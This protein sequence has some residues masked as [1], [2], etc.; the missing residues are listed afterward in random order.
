MKKISM[1]LVVTMLCM[2]FPF[3]GSLVYA[4]VPYSGIVI[5]SGLS[6]AMGII[7][8]PDDK[9]YISDYGGNKI[10]KMDKDGSNL[11]TLTTNV[12][13]PIGLAFDNSGNLLVA[14]Y[15]GHR[16]K[17]VD[18][19]GNTTL[20]KG[21][22][23]QLTG[24]VVDS[25]NKIFVIDYSYGKIY[26]MDADGSNSA[27]FATVLKGSSAVTSSLIGLGIDASDNLYLSDQRNARILKID[28]NG[29]QSDFASVSAPYWASVG[30]NGY[31]YASAI[32]RTIQKFDLSGNKIET[33]STGTYIPWGTQVDTG[34]SIY[35]V[36]FG[37]NVNKILGYADTV[38]RT[39]VKIT[40][41]YDLVSGTADASAFTLSGVSSTPQ[42]TSAVVN[43][44][45]IDLTLDS[46]IESTDTMAKVNYTKTGT[47]NLVQQGTSIEID[48][49][50][51][52]VVAN[53]I[54][55]VASV[56]TPSPINVAN[57]TALNAVGLPATVTVNLS[58][59]TTTT[60]SAAVVWD[61]GT[62][63]YDGNTAGTY[64]FSG[65]LSLGNDIYNPDNKKATVDVVVAAPVI[66]TV[67]SMSAINVIT[68][69]NGTELSAVG[70]P[71]SVSF[72]LSNST[73][74]SAAIVWDGGTPTYD[75]ETVGTYTFTGTIASSSDYL[76]S[77][78]IKASVDVIVTAKP[79]VTTTS[80]INV[81]TV[82][83]GTVLSSVGLPTTV[84][85]SLSNSTTT[86]AAV[87]WDAGTPAYDGEAA[88]NY[89]FTGTIA[90][91]NDYI[92]PNHVKASVQVV[93]QSPYDKDDNGGGSVPSSSGMVEVNG[94]T[95]KVSDETRTIDNGKTKVKVTIDNVSMKK[96]LSDLLEKAASSQTFA[97][98]LATINVQDTNADSTVIDLD[99]EIVKQMDQNK[100]DILV[101]LGDKTY[102]IPAEALAVDAIATRLAVPQENLK[103]IKFY[104]QVDKIAPEDQT[105]ITQKAETNNAKMIIEATEF[106]ISAVVT[107]ND[108]TSETV[109][110]DTFKQYVKRGFE[111][112]KGINIG[113]VTT[114]VVFDQDYNYNQVP[115]RIYTENGVTYVEIN[116]LTNSIYS[117][118]SNPITVNSVKGH[119]SESI[120]NDMA[121]RLVLTDYDQFKADQNVT[122]GEFANYMT[123]ALGL[124]KS[125]AS[126]E[127]SFT[128]VKMTD[129]NAAEIVLAAQWGLVSGYEDGKFKPDNEITRE[130]AMVLFAKAMEIANYAGVVGSSSFDIETNANISNWSKPY[131]QKVLDGK[132]FVGRSNHDLGLKEN[133]THAETLAALRNLLIKAELINEK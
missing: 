120:V 112:P 128:D 61:G 12:S 53:H 132:V 88:G 99:G 110:V 4:D 127:S 106:K 103:S 86:S 46:N 133:L 65:T 107:R 40:L 87:V 71:S 44:S 111:I 131:I 21:G 47:N 101:N 2:M 114:G 73:T 102:K 66:P 130:E 126:F 122:R 26:K 25:H 48:A 97:R 90:S 68:V 52:L 98:N 9:V 54:V 129:E 113:D 91:S 104:I 20:I 125:D 23:G 27:V 10:V 67:T 116:S 75:G 74:T 58:N 62:P 49:F 78:S 95:Q 96:V 51:N 77:N 11:T 50:S 123:R 105:A 55:G 108:G 121:S 39:H 76:N 59:S 22:L 60:T 34:G 84:S 109:E 30:K 13:E 24:I 15:G 70:L 31:V 57:G 82:P 45:E 119:W 5:A 56:G 43:G 69:P 3:T 32:D 36:H 100:F 85:F 89:A 94:V 79:H 64:T 81:I 41:F 28:S 8:G 38:D 33:Y 18:S 37:A 17:K 115:T 93:V 29:V 16:I 124:Y 63:A 118:I 6:S 72:S 80:A 35:F 7:F 117:V 83:N 42:V 14:E 92:N 1:L 19:G